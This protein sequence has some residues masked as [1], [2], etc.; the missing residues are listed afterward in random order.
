MSGQSNT[1]AV[2][3]LRYNPS[4]ANM[5]VW[6]GSTWISISAST[7]VSLTQDTIELLEWAR[8]ERNKQLRYKAMAKDNVT[9]ADALES[10]KDA[11]LRL[12]ELAILC[13][14][15]NSNK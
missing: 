15:S 9:L 6:D 1:G 2:G 3:M 8:K 7:D 10:V 4:S 11:E 13:D 14:T 5:E 12:L